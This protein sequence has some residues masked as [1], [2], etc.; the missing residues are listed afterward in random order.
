MNA[1]ASITTSPTTMR[2]P[3]FLS[4]ALLPM[5]LALATVD[6]SDVGRRFPS[7]KKSFVD[8]VTGYPITVLT[9][10]PANDVRI[11]QTH[12]QWTV[13]GEYI[14]FPTQ[15]RAADKN[16]QAFAVH[17]SSGE[18]IQLT[19][20]PG[21][22]PRSLNLSHKREALFYLRNARVKG[23]GSNAIELVEL[24]LGPLLADSKAGV[25]KPDPT[26]Y[27][28]VVK[29]L[30]DR[31]EG[32]AL[33]ADEKVVYLRLDR[34]PDDQ[35]S[36]TSPASAEASPGVTSAHAEVLSTIYCVDLATGEGK[37]IFKAPFMLGH[38]Q[39]NPLRSG[40]FTYCH[41]TGGDAE[42]RMFFMKA[43]GSENRPLYPET[44]GEWITHEAFASE[45]E[46]IFNILGHQPELRRR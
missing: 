42:Q 45:N 46:V 25:M 1:P 27:E 6:A 28:R 24:A 26:A 5:L 33:D 32:M 2:F 36:G 35:V 12:P 22:H 19:D 10:S 40:E 34:P 21:L 39:A 29:T 11:Y 43:D 31:V 17:E 7:E 3:H 41:E 44:P 13:S 4:A 9:S 38:L 30:T 18:I 37:E 23:S 8:E 14:V 15:D 16:V 20:G